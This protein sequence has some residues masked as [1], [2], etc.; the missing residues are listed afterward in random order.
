MRLGHRA[1]GSSFPTDNLSSHVDSHKSG[2]GRGKE[3]GPVALVSPKRDRSA[4]FCPYAARE[5]LAAFCGASILTREECRLHQTAAVLEKSY[6][7]GCELS[8]NS[9]ERYGLFSS[10]NGMLVWEHEVDG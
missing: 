9:H 10:F 2:T 1:A 5:P 6:L 8:S 3:T 4:R 7:P